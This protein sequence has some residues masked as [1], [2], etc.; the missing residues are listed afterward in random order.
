[1]PDTVTTSHPT[2]CDPRRCDDQGSGTTCHL[3]TVHIVATAVPGESLGI[4]L[5]RGDTHNGPATGQPTTVDLLHY[6]DGPD[7]A[8]ATLISLPVEAVSHLTAI[9][10]ASQT[11]K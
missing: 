3:S 6:P 1:M 5:S 2:W 8:A 7:A 9:L 4:Q 10:A 11:R